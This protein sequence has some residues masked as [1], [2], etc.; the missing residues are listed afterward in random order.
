MWKT[1]FDDHGLSTVDRQ[2]SHSPNARRPFRWCLGG[3]SHWSRGERNVITGLLEAWRAD[4]PG[5]VRLDR[6][7]VLMR[8]IS[9]GD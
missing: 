3:V 7:P 9:P 4:Q 2:H 5:L 1:L 8:E 6:R